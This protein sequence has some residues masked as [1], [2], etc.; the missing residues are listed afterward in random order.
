MLSGST[1]RASSTFG[2]FGFHAGLGFLSR[3]F[4]PQD[5]SQESF[6]QPDYLLAATVYSGLDSGVQPGKQTNT[7]EV[8]HEYT[9][10]P[11]RRPLALST[12]GYK[13]P[14]P[15]HHI[16][17]VGHLGNRHCGR[18]MQ[19]PACPHRPHHALHGVWPRV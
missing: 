5:S 11:K 13:Q 15:P 1:R 3:E 2:V 7:Y 10:D 14:W 18:W 6:L 19:V 12:Q 8:L 17:Q 4:S 9:R 16:K